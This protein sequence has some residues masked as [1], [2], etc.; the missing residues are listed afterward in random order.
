[1]RL[2]FGEDF[3]SYCLGNNGK[4]CYFTYSLSY[5]KALVVT[6]IALS[7]ARQRH[8]YDAVYAIKEPT[9]H[10][11]FSS[12]S[13]Q[14]KAYFWTAVVFQ[15]DNNAGVFGMWVVEKER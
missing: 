8:R 4:S 2:R 7:F 11:S 15:V 10:K 1:M 5:L 9:W 14:V 6:T 12:V 3:T 13:T